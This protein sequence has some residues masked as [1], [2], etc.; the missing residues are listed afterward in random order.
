MK[1]MMV[2]L[3]EE[4]MNA[5]KELAINTVLTANRRN[6]NLVDCSSFETMRRLGIKTIFT[7]DEHSKEQG[8]QVI[9]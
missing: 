3:T 7:F 1:R 4:Q 8:F 6:L 2:Q 5:L 9:P